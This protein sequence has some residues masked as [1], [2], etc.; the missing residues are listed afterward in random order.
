MDGTGR[1]GAPGLRVVVVGATGNVGSSLLPLLARDPGVAEV[2][3]LARRVPPPGWPPTEGDSGRV[4]FAPVDIGA[5]GCEPE[6]AAHFAG[7]DAVVHLAWLMRLGPGE[8]ERTWRTNALGSLRVFDAVA[9]AGVPALVYASSVGAYAPGPGDGRPVDEG[10][11]AHGW[12]GS[13]YT[14]EKAYVERCL[15]TFER[16]HPEVRVVRMRPSFLFKRA[17]AQQQRELFAGPLVRSWMVRRPGLLPVLPFPRGL[18][19]QVCHT[20]DAAEAYRLAVHGPGRGAFNL[21]AEPPLDAKL[22][23]G[24]LGARPLP[25]PP[26]LP[27]AALSAG[28][29]LRLVH[30]APG[31]Y[32][33]LLRLPLLDAGRAGEVLG[34]RAV[35]S[36]PETVAEFLEGLRCGPPGGPRPPAD[37][38]APA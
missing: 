26:A 27:R 23:A 34:W 12:P 2:L 16:D 8:E 36:A 31:L 7:A 3:G 35:R 11:P 15:D 24:L 13:A 20:E 22:L 18:R 38:P 9:R 6:L 37:P 14:R 25:V 10:W 19:L 21:A 33:A 1:P 5:E 32:D 28:W 4:R 30:A 17:S 29:H